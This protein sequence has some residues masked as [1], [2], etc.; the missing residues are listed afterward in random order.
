MNLD[1][2]PPLPSL[3]R[4]GTRT[5]GSRDV[6]T[7]LDWLKAALTELAKVSADVVRRAALDA[8]DGMAGGGERVNGGRYLEDGSVPGPIPSIVLGRYRAGRFV[9]G[10]WV[11]GEWAG[12]PVEQAMSR[13]VGGIA[14]ARA[15]IEQAVE[16]AAY[17]AGVTPEEARELLE[18]IGRGG[19]QAGYCVNR[20]CGRWVAGTVVDRMRAGRCE[21]CYRWRLRHDGEDR[22]AEL[23][24]H[25]GAE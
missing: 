7:Q 24:A 1:P 8:P 12:D 17:L 2:P 5:W 14:G 16:A 9:G 23:C 21:A 25:E 22:P 6:R 3:H 4:D 19:R 10:R 15:A 13:F 18:L 11:P 20:N